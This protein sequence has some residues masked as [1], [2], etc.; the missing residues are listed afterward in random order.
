MRQPEAHKEICL[1]AK[2]FFAFAVGSVSHHAYAQNYTEV[3]PNNPCPSAQILGALVV[4]AQVT[5]YKGLG[6]VEFL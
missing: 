5:G 1:L 3:E 2:L 4:P 6:D